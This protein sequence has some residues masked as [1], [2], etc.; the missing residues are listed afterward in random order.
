MIIGSCKGG[1]SFGQLDILKGMKINNG[2]VLVDGKITWLWINVLF[3]RTFLAMV[4][5]Y[6][7]ILLMCSLSLKLG[8][9][10]NVIVETKI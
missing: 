8:I 7:S 3:W 4:C 10:T 2:S 9:L 5:H 6:M 1:S